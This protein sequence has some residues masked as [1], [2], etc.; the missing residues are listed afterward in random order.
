MRDS[1]KRL[2]IDPERLTFVER[3]PMH[4]Y[5]EQHGQSD[6]GLDPFPYGGGTTTYDAL[7]MGV[8]DSRSWWPE[9][10]R[11]TSTLRPVSLPIHGNPSNSDRT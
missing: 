10:W 5:L 3:V 4:D 7:W 1:L 9:A 11:S 2:G 6:I 8:P